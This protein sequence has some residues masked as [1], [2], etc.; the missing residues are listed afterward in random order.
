M[1]FKD[2]LRTFRFH[3]KTE[4]Y[5]QLYTKWGEQLDPEHVLKNT[6]DLNFNGIIIGF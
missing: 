6:Q 4:N 2:A 5:Y 3:K 1:N